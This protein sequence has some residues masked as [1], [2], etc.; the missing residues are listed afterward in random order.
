MRPQREAL[1]RHTTPMNASDVVHKTVF[2]AGGAL[3]PSAKA[4]HGTHQ[5]RHALGPL[6]SR[7]RSGPH[8]LASADC[9]A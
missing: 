5:R 6:H 3:K 7:S 2:K 9:I 1:T 4:T 8:E